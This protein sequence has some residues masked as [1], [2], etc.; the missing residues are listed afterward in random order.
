MPR[1]WLQIE[2]ALEVVCSQLLG[3]SSFKNDCHFGKYIRVTDFAGLPVITL[4]ARRATGATAPAP[5]ESRNRCA[6]GVNTSG[7]VCAVVG[8]GEALAQEVH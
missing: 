8:G 1:Q 6:T 7:G 3:K 4:D 2:C 5:A